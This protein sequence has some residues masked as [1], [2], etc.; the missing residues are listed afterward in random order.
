MHMIQT[1]IDHPQ[2]QRILQPAHP[3]MVHSVTMAFQIRS[4]DRELRKIAFPYKPPTFR[5]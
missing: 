1:Q 2:F 5:L 4:Q 3:F